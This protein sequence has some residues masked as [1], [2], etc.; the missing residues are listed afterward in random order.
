MQRP[1]QSIFMDR[2]STPKSSNHRR[3]REVRKETTKARRSMNMLLVE[4]IVAVCIIIL[5]AIAIECGFRFGIA[6]QI[7]AVRRG[8]GEL[9]SG[10][11][12]AIQGAVLG[13]LG[14]LLGFSFAGASS[15]YAE[16]QHLVVAE[17]NA[18]G[19]LR[20]RAQLLDEPHRGNL[21]RILSEYIDVRIARLDATTPA[22]RLTLLTKAESLQDSIW[23]NAKEGV[24]AKPLTIMAVLPPTNEVLDLYTTQRAASRRHLPAPVVILLIGSAML[25]MATVG[26]GSGITGRRQFGLITAVG[27]LVASTLC[28]TLDLDY[29]A[30]GI[31]HVDDTP[32]R[33]LKNASAG[34]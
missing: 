29:P 3:R 7:G 18:L 15:R 32:I 26:Y 17:A 8:R 13:L 1:P 11:I 28:T 30:A 4:I 33:A 2:T 25:A 14:L 24:E 16:R 22:E 23:N 10:Q 6:A 19:T 27:L 5:L 12:G 9:P 31:I 34:N 21:L 20:L